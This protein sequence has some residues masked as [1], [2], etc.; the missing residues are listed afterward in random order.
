MARTPGAAGLSVRRLQRLQEGMGRYVS[1]GEV[2]GVA[3]LVS[4]GGQVWVDSIGCQNRDRADPMRRDTIFRIASMSKPVTAVAAMML[5]EEG[6]LGLDQPLDEWLPELA[7]RRV[8]RRID[9]PLE[10]TEPACRAL[11]LRDLLTF[12]M[13]FGTI[14][15][16]SEGFPIQQA[17]NALHIWGRKPRPPH[18]PDEWLRRLGTLPLM[19]QP[20]EHWTYHTGADVAGVLIARVAG[21]PFETFLHERLFEPLGMRNTAFYVPAGKLERLAS[22]YQENPLTSS[23]TL[24]DDACDSQWSRPPAFPSGGSGLLST[25]DDYHAFA[26]MMLHQGR[27]G[28]VRILARPTVQAMITDQLTTEQKGRSTAF[29]PTFWDA[30][31]W[32]FGMAVITRRDGP[33]SNPGRF[34]W[35]GVYGTSW[36]SDPAEG[37]VGILMIQ[38]LDFAPTIAGINADFWTLVYQAIED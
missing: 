6:R 25:L 3:M 17:I 29:F 35:D 12:R 20:G 36:Y 18:S 24:F 19:Y 21:Q 1:R 38:R 5:V 32:G 11:T 22:C 7:H 27:L 8:L 16:P 15:G 34:G 13:G 33:S 31:G 4:R 26:Q 14:L 30:R 2:A 37:L 10:D 9:G 23:I 28:D